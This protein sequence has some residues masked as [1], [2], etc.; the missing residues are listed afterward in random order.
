[1]SETEPKRKGVATFYPRKRN[2]PVT[3]NLTYEAHAE[4]E[5]VKACGASRG[6]VLEHSFRK[7]VGL[8][9]NPVLEQALAA[10]GTVAMQVS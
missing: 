4:M 6:D 10:L 8:P 9:V 3:I 2:S 7:L 5:R 1:M